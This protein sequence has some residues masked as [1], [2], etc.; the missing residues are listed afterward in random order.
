MHTKIKRY[1]KSKDEL[2]KFEKAIV[3][4]HPE[5]L[6]TGCAEGRRGIGKSMFCY[7]VATRIFQYLDGIHV[8][9]A[10]I[11]ALDHFIWTTDT[12]MKMVDD[13]I[14]ETDFDNIR[15][16]DMENKYR[17]LV[18]DDVGTHMSKY[19]FYVDVENVDQL[20]KRLDVIRDVTCGLFMTA[21][22]VSGLLSFLREY[23]DVRN[24]NIAYDADGNTKLDRIIEVREQPK[25]WARK[26]RLVFPPIKTSIFVYD[27]AYDEYKIRKRKAELKLFKSDENKKNIDKLIRI[28][29][30]YN[31]NLKPSEIIEKLELKENFINPKD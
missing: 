21:P 19:Q 14:K 12:F 10:Y 9:D 18:I 13:V 23:P 22:A 28:V 7:I 27:W 5:G 16:Y 1:I 2:T 25:K 11:K 3:N 20:K 4:S 8:D 31:P 26:G 17:I 29:K 30:Q 6:S 15:Q 24:I